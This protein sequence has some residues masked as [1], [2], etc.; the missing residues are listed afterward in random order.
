MSDTCQHTASKTSDHDPPSGQDIVTA[1]KGSGIIFVGQLFEYASRFLFGII[2]ARSIGAKGYGLYNIGDTVA[3]TISIFALLG[4][5]SGIVRFLPAALGEGDEERVWGILQVAIGLVGVVSLLLAV[6][7]FGLS[8]WVAQDLFH[9]PAAAPVLRLA[10][11][12]IPLATMGNLLAA[13][14]RGFNR[15]RYQVYANSIAFNA[16][17]IVLTVLVLSLGLGLSGVFAAGAVA[18]AITVGLLVYF[19]NQLFP[20][21][22]PLRAAQRNTRQLLSFS[23]PLLLAQAIRQLGS[24]IEI[25][26]LSMM[27]TVTSVGVYGAAL[28]IQMVGTALLF[29]VQ[30]AASPIIADLHDQG[31]HAQLRRL[32][33]TLTKW[34]FSFSL[35][36]FLTTVLFAEPM[37]AIFGQDF[38]VG[39]PILVIEALGT[40]VNAGNGICVIMINMTGYSKL[41]FCNALGS[42]ILR[43]TLDVLLIRI[44]GAV[45]AAVATCLVAVVMTAVLLLEVRWLLKAWPFDLTFLKPVAAGFVALIVGLVMARLAPAG[46]N[47]FYLVLDVGL[48]W[49]G[50]AAVTLLLRLS[51]EDQMVVNRVKMQF[52]A[53]LRQLRTPSELSS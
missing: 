43:L 23:L 12:W 52:G 30:T 18:T 31:N 49:L 17:R 5:P 24:Q 22:R 35:P 38:T 37:L 39:T 19:L 2:L 20:L 3:G 6:G 1:A 10:S 26:I 47:L 16:S 36:F 48:L 29:A 11:I 8:D 7:V 13:A 27:V 21:R 14:T 41:S 28:R 34:A 46:L 25:L 42:L 51:E 9:E 15:M 40:L 53:K 4:L 32:Y 44:W 33:R 45:G 50:Y